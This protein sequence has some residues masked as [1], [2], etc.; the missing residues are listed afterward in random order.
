M[1]CEFPLFFCWQ[2][3]AGPFRVG[4]SNVP[5]HMRYGIISVL[6]KLGVEDNRRDVVRRAVS[7]FRGVVELAKFLQRDFVNVYKKRGDRD[8]MR[9]PFVFVTIIETHRELACWNMDHA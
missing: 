8:F 2:T 9:G 5:I 4:I 3:L 6:L 7:M 1:R